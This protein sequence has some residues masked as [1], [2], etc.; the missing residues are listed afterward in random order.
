MENA[1]ACELSRANDWTLRDII[2][3][4]RNLG[5][6]PERG[7]SW[8]ASGYSIEDYGTGEEIEYTLHI[9]GVTPST[10]ARIARFLE[11]GR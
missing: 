4:A 2:R 8:L 10:Y 6:G 11:R 1:R 3:E 9:E 5:I 7:C